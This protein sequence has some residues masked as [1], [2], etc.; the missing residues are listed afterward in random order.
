MENAD[1]LRVKILNIHQDFIDEYDLMKH[2]CIGWAYL[3]IL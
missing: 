1:Y 3:E 2:I